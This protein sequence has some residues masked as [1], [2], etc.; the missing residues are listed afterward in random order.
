MLNGVCFCKNYYGLFKKVAE[1]YGLSPKTVRRIWTRGQEDNG[2]VRH[3]VK[4]NKGRARTEE[5]LKCIN[6]KINNLPE[7]QEK[8]LRSIS[9]AVNVPLSSL[10][11]YIATGVVSRKKAKPILGKN[12]MGVRISKET[13]SLKSRSR[14]LQCITTEQEHVIPI[15]HETTAFV[16]FNTIQ[17][18][19]MRFECEM[20]K[21]Q[22]VDFSQR[23]ES[24]E[25]ALGDARLENERLKLSNAE[26]SGG[27]QFDVLRTHVHHILSI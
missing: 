27:V 21:A 7:L 26:H 10:H 6:E 19:A 25:S 16:D 9:K 1:K 5:Q 2:N 24:L 22:N 13:S 18:H 3:R 4:G 15:D 11:K 20:L 23:L 17:V 12:N 14:E 8:D